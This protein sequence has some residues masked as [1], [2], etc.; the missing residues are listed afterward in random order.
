M[1]IAA[2]ADPPVAVCN[3][4]GRTTWAQ[5]S[6]GSDDRMDHITGGRCGGRFIATPA[7]DGT[8]AKTDT[9]CAADSR[10]DQRHSVSDDSAP[11]KRRSGFRDSVR[12]ENGMT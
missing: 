8:T 4:C 2:L 12:G 1:I 7:I 6:I 9:P 5:A 10:I 11:V 3:R